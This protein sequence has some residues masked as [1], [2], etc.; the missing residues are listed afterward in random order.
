MQRDITMAPMVM[1]GDISIP[2]R[3]L[4]LA[5]LFAAEIL[6]LSLRFDTASLV[7]DRSWWM[8]LVGHLP[9]ALRICLAFG[10]ALGL[11]LWP[12]RMAILAKAQKAVRNHAW[13]RTLALHLLV[14]G[15]FTWM[16]F[17]LFGS[18]ERGQR[19]PAWA[20][21]GWFGL[22]LGNVLLW[23]TT[24][25]PMGFWLWLAKNEKTAFLAAMMTGTTAWVGGLFA[26]QLW[27]P[28][29]EGT[30]WLAN[31]LLS[32]VYT[33]A[34]YDLVNFGLGTPRFMVRIAPQCSGYE[35][36]GLIVVFL[37]LYL[38]LF[39]AEIRFARAWLLFPAGILAMWLANALR[40]TL[41]IV[42]GNSVSRDVA[43]GGF[44][45]QAGW[46]CFILIAL[47]LIAL[48]RR[49]RWLTPKSASGPDSET[50]L[51]GENAAAPLLVPIMALMAGMMLGSAFSAGIDR[52]YALR[53]ALAAGA[54]W[55]Y[56]RSY[57]TWMCR[58]DLASACV[59]V[60]V[61]A[62][63][64]LLEPAGGN[65]H[66]LPD[67]L[68]KLNS[69]ERATW[70][71]FRAGGSVLVVPLVEELAF[72]GYLLRRLAG[73]DLFQSKPLPFSWFAL[74]TS[75]LLFGLLHGRWLAG[76]LAGLAYGL[77]CHRRSQLADA[78][79][80][81]AITNALIALSVLVFGRWSLWG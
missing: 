37:S 81:H 39:R 71:A 5:L 55:C 32:V 49:W 72:R 20:V 65:H 74:V 53:I 17:A 31:Q 66:A 58:P 59:G 8:E 30:F 56:R 41:L 34:L 75:S 45:S 13:K 15:L 48:M 2:L 54:L 19:L 33:D 42:I 77:I 29:A 3:I 44:H 78:V 25:A 80:A 73:A 46:I 47:G 28:L 14:F 68:A 22:G 69:L 61:F 38:W 60:A 40:I 7:G 4:A 79:T 52:W 21:G 26:E 63:W 50:T 27:H 1:K 9:E 11:I 51:Q 64:M 35:G 16:T 23:L 67:A 36:M 57:L 18:A 43:L 12:Q 62:L 10:G 76:L 6:A 70:L 24:L